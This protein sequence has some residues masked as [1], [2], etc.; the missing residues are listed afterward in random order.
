VPPI[1]SA[2]GLM[3]ALQ[4]LVE[5]YDGRQRLRVH[6]NLPQNG[7]LRPAGLPPQISALL[8]SAVRELLQNVLKHAQASTAQVT[9]GDLE[10]RVSVAVEDNGRGFER[11][12][13]EEQSS[14]AAA[15]GENHD[16]RDGFGLFS[17]RTRLLYVGGEMRIIS[18]AGKGTHITLIAPPFDSTGH[19]EGSAS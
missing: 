1:L 5:R 17:I 19:R 11:E 18:A 6:L 2:L 9:V 8:F 15:A 4:W 3:P 16:K 14:G 13:I 7:E 12:H 10:G